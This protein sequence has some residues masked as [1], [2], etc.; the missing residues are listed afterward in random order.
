MPDSTISAYERYLGTPN[1][2]K[3]ENSFDPWFVAGMHKRL[4]ELYEAKGDRDR[5][6]SHYL[7]FVALWKHADPELQPK[8]ANV[9]RRLAR[10][11]DVER[12]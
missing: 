1:I 11:G 3:L 2:Q 10:L 8:V 9:R 5:A 12:P 6:V 7:Q 4:G